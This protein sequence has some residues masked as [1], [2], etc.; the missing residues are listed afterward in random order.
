[1]LKREPGSG[2]TYHWWNPLRKGRC[3]NLMLAGGGMNFM[4]G[5]QATCIELPG[6]PH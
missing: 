5:V 1:L 2:S 3:F 6:Q 4:D